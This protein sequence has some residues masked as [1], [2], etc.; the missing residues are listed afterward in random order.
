MDAPVRI[1]RARASDIPDLVALRQA[2]FES[3]GYGDPTLLE[4]VAEANEA[5]LATALPRGEFRAWV[6]E[7]SGKVVASGGLVIH[8]VPPTAMNLVGM[9]GYIM[10]MYT[11]PEWRRQGL[12]TAILQTILEHLRQEGIPLASLHASEQGRR[13]YEKQGFAS[14]NEMRLWLGW[15]VEPS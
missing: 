14:S 12:G 9:E 11:R 2:L 4:A 10:N 7:A 8:V 13:L 6:A 5:Y 1:R 3:M 15:Q